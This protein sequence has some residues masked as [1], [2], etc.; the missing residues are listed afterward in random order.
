MSSYEIKC[1]EKASKLI[2]KLIIEEETFIK[3]REL[4]LLGAIKRDDIIRDYVD[5]LINT[6]R[7]HVMIAR[8]LSRSKFELNKKLA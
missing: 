2:D 4:E 1:L 3:S 6:I 5:G 7:V 8:G